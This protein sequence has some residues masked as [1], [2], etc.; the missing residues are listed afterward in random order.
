MTTE[1]GSTIQTRVNNMAEKDGDPS[2]T[3]TMFTTLLKAIKNLEEKNDK[4]NENLRQEI[5][6]TPNE[7]S[8]KIEDKLWH[9]QTKQVEFNGQVEDVELRMEKKLD[10]IEQM[11]H[12]KLKTNQNEMTQLS[13]SLY[14]KLEI[15]IEITSRTIE[16]QN[17]HI[18]E[19]ESQ[20]VCDYV[21]K[22]SS[23]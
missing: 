8:V 22:Y 12:E 14:K 17:L 6:C 9:N 18:S 19:I 16:T 1:S 20:L 7:L 15:H 4:I 2:K 21:G 10:I 13:M 11:F 5:Q 23:M 3:K